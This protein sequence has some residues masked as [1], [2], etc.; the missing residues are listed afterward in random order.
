MSNKSKTGS[1]FENLV[2]VFIF[3]V[4][5][6]TFL[7]DFAILVGWS[8]QIR[9]ILV[10]TGMGFDIFFV[11][12]FLVRLFYAISGGRV[13]HYLIHQRG[14]IDFL[15]SV[16]L[17]MLNSGP[18][19]ISMIL[20][21]SAFLGLGGFLNV[22]KVVKA[23][24]IARILRLLRV[25]KIV[26]Q[27]KYADST[28]AQRHVAKIT[29]ISITVF[30]FSL[31]AYTILTPYIGMPSIEKDY[32]ARQ[33][34]EMMQLYETMQAGETE[35]ALSIAEHSPDLLVVKKG[36]E[37]VYTAFDNSYYSKFIGP[38]DYRYAGR[39]PYGFFYD[40]REINKHQSGN[41]ILF[42]AIVVIFVVA[43]IVLYSPHFAITVSDPIQVMK[44]GLDESSYNLEVRIPEAYKDDDVFELADKYNEIYLPLKDRSSAEEGGDMVE[45]KMDDFSDLF[46]DE[47]Q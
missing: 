39:V 42:F 16:P 35:A 13:K 43:F 22:L 19:G 37:T 33:N 47:Q 1:F 25:L 45:L 38:G 5:I 40:A 31:F 12:E 20:G 23:V 17:L 14:W 26:K 28:M 30:V 36:G 29:T 44:R 6:Q 34:A 8:W 46:E 24:R 41:N 21:G 27:L 32:E 7:E 4:L 11:T 10:F 2:I 18:T 15:A 9:S 3:L